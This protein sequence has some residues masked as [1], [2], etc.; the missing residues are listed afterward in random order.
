[1][2]IFL[3]KGVKKK[4]EHNYSSVHE[5]VKHGDALKLEEMIKSGAGI[6]EVNMESKFTPMHTACYVGSLEVGL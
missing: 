2:C 5:A 3:Y 1:M 6:N 4:R